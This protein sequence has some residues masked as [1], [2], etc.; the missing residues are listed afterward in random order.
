M[1]C[2]GLGARREGAVRDR[3]AV[4]AGRRTLNASGCGQCHRGTVGGD[5]GGLGHGYFLSKSAETLP[6][7]ATR[8]ER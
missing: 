3:S 1:R 8:I 2:S 5:G 7:L 4:A 6:V